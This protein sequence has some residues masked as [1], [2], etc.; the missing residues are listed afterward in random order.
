M[1][2]SWE[3]KS[4]ARSHMSYAQCHALKMLVYHE[5]TSKSGT[6]EARGHKCE[7]RTA[8]LDSPLG[9]RSSKRSYATKTL[10][11]QCCV[12]QLMTESDGLASN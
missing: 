2:V 6:S 3:H 1:I 4:Q 12:G 8:V 9:E 7:S 5:P 11:F 10:E